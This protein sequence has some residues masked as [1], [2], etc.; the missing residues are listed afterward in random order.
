MLIKICFCHYRAKA[1]AQK[2]LFLLLSVSHRQWGLLILHGKVAVSIF[3]YATDSSSFRLCFFVRNLL[4]GS[5][6][7]N[8]SWSALKLH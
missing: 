8:Q 4:G 2:V 6:R 1:A 3:N 5:E 7:N